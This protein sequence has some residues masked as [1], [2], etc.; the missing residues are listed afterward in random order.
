MWAWCFRC[1][2]IICLQS[3]IPSMQ[4]LVPDKTRQANMKQ[5]HP[6]LDIWPCPINIENTS[7]MLFLVCSLWPGGGGHSRLDFIAENNISSLSQSPTHT[8]H[9]N[10]WD[11]DRYTPHQLWR[12]VWVRIIF[13]PCYGF[14]HKSLKLGSVILVFT[15]IEMAINKNMYFF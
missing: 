13:S 15:E 5:S 6:W 9:D 10:Q 2:E 3:I 12:C 14:L 7:S 4:F 1:P 11:G 8:V